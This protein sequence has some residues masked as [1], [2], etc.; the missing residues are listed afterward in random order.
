M[1]YAVVTGTSKG[2]GESI[3]KLLMQAAFHVIGIARNGNEGLENADL[4]GEYTHYQADLSNIDQTRKVFEQ[5]IG[6]LKEKQDIESLHLVQNAA[7]INPIE[8][9]GKQDPTLIEQHMNVNLVSPMVITNLWLDSWQDQSIPLVLVHVTSGAAD[10]SVYGWTAYCASKAGLNRFTRTVALEQEE[11]NTGNKVFLFDPSIMDTEM[12]GEIRSANPSQ[13][14]DV[15][16][17]RNY[18][19]NKQLRSTDVVAKVLVDRLLDESTI[20]NGEY[21]S[22]KDVFK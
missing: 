8:Q 12:Q 6:D 11:L 4:P 20:E 16:N 15:E 21:Y 3:A 10:R 18:Q 5:I 9:A 22:V 13:F 14:I 1:N 2:L 19:T 7:L 17:F